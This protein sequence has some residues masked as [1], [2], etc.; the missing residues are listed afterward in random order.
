MLYFFLFIILYYY[1]AKKNHQMLVFHEHCLL[2]NMHITIKDQTSIS[3]KG[4]NVS[5][6]ILLSNV[7]INSAVLCNLKT[8]QN[9]IYGSP[10]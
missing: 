1:F 5:F 10:I 9:H 4:E 7:L 3:T 6:I 8:N 2:Q